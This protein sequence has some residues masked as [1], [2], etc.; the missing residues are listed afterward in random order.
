MKEP[1]YLPKTKV[2]FKR[3][4]GDGV[5]EGEVTY[6]ETHWPSRGGYCGI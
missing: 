2:Y 5:Y 4:K 6:V 3:H 1:K